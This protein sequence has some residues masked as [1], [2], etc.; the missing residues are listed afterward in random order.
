ML[1]IQ[2][3]DCS[4]QNKEGTI[5]EGRYTN[6]PNDQ[7]GFAVVKNVDKCSCLI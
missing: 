1:L 6:V 7:A 5:W 2:K 4:A 3:V